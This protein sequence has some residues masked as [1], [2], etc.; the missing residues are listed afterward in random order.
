MAC[1]IGNMMM[2]M[3][4]MMMFNMPWETTVVTVVSHSVMQIY[5]GTRC[6]NEQVLQ[7]ILSCP[8]W[9]YPPTSKPRTVSDGVVDRDDLAV[10]AA[11]SIGDAHLYSS[12][13]IPVT[14]SLFNIHK[15]PYNEAERRQ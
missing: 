11:L 15:W 14:S 1:S 12:L 13:D 2:M 7:Y 10:K 5:V 4:M 3:M 6:A 9:A 8:N